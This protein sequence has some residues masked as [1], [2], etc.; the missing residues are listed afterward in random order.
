VKQMM[1]Q[2]DREQTGETVEVDLDNVIAQGGEGKICKINNL[3]GY[4]AKIFFNPISPEKLEKLQVMIANPPEDAMKQQGH[5]T[6]A[7]PEDLLKDNQGNY[8][9]FIMPEILNSQILFN[10]YH[11]ETRMERASGFTWYHLHNTAK[12]LAIA[13]E[14]LHAKGYVIGDLKP[15]NILV[16]SQSLVSIVDTDSFQVLNPQTNKIYRCTVGS[17]EYTPPE[18]I[19]EDFK[20]VDREKEHDRFSLAILIHLLLFGYHPF[21]GRVKNYQQVSTP[22]I[23]K[24]ISQGYCIYN[25]DSPVSPAPWSMPL[26]IIDSGLQTL[27]RQCFIGGHKDNGNRPSAETWR[28]YLDIGIENL[29]KCSHNENHY[30]DK[31]YGRCHWCEREGVIISNNNAHSSQTSEGTIQISVNSVSQQPPVSASSQQSA[32]QQ[33]PVSASSQQSASQQPPVSASSQQ[34]NLNSSS[35]KQLAAMGV[36]LITAFVVGFTVMP[37]LWNN[38]PSPEIEHSPNSK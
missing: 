10:V 30:Y 2:L 3:S 18:L 29:V 25:P 6:F 22:T 20:T 15:Q 33:P 5:M 38:L 27:F 8:L 21:Q 26:Q 1:T 13:V 11:Y 31:D 36:G 28:T 9:G 19:G 17:A 23:D 16:N 35:F 24:S 4:V 32:S 14:A 37:P 34:S 12:N 7:W